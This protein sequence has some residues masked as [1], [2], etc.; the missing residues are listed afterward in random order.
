MKINKILKAKNCKTNP[1]WWGTCWTPAHPSRPALRAACHCVEVGTHLHG[2]VSSH[3]LPVHPLRHQ[4]GDREWFSVPDLGCDSRMKKML[5]E[6]QLVTHLHR[7]PTL[8]PNLPQHPPHTHTLKFI[9][10]CM[11]LICERLAFFTHPHPPSTFFTSFSSPPS[12]FHPTNLHHLPPSLSLLP[13]LN[14]LSNPF[15]LHSNLRITFPKSPLKLW[16]AHLGLVC[17]VSLQDTHIHPHHPPLIIFPHFTHLI[18]TCN[19]PTD[20]S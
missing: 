18:T 8:N 17:N 5:L 4:S 2:L 6:W 7:H 13:S 3:T 10:I 15:F 12:H 9:H 14:L 1:E 11:S 19:S 16:F 20:N